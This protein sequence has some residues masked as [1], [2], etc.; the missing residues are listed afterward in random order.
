M[1]GELVGRR[2]RIGLGW[3]AGE[4]GF[5]GCFMSLCK[6]CHRSFVGLYKLEYRSV[7]SS[8]LLKIMLAW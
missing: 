7:L 1:L 4:A 3:S 2:G 5:D 6:A 8:I